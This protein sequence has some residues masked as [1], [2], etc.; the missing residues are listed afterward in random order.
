MAEK[1]F[2]VFEDVYV[3]GRWHLDDPLDSAGRAVETNLFRN[4]RPSHVEE[5]LRVPLY[6]PGEA[7][8]F[9][10]VAGTTVPVVHSRVAVVLRE[11]AP[12]D[13]E[14]IPAR[15][16]G[17]SDLYFFLNI[18]RVV[19]CIDDAASDEVRY[20]TPEH[21][22]PEQLGEYRSVIGMRIDPSKVGDAQV[23]RTW[24][25]TVSIIFSETIKVAL[26][27]LGVTGMSFT[28]V[29]GPSDISPEE[30]ERSRQLRDLL[31][32]AAAARDAAWRTLGALDADVF[33]PIAVGGAWPGHRQLWRVIRRDAGR[34]LLVTHG[35]SDAFIDTLTPSV[36]F[37][38]ELALEVDAAVKDITQGWPLL[39]L[40]RVADEVAEH[41]HVREGLLAGLFSMEVAGKGLPKAFLSPEGRV[42]VLLGLSAP[43]MPEAFSTP[44]GR[45]RL[46]TVKVLLPAEL[47][48][49]LAHG[50]E[51]HAELAR[52]FSENGEALLSRTRRRA[53]V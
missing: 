11:L 41:A 28:E 39:L 46:V 47:A 18:T 17:Q 24:G 1:F 6:V 8:D 36:G 25:W 52:R 53:V 14:L 50:A 5:T 15:I 34:T 16:D 40:E 20:V 44:Y 10:F 33:M 23:F 29:T 9:S 43:S 7:L 32:T 21:E 51:G 49:V 35:L 22:L 45:V 42:A 37:G 4:S 2:R 3:P 38:L 30:R 12:N 13:V 19:K 27:R 31:E 26:E 48:Y